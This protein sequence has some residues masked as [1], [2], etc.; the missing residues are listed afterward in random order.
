MFNYTKNARNNFELIEKAER[1]LSLIV[2]RK[3]SGDA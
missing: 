3:E 2:S 1:I